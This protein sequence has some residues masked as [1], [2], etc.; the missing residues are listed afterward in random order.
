MDKE[1]VSVT[2]AESGDIIVNFKVGISLSVY[3][4]ALNSINEMLGPNAPVVISGSMG[5]KMSLPPESPVK[6]VRKSSKN[7]SNKSGKS[8]SSRGKN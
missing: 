5:I 2:L 7:S 1:L 3:T 8:K 4:A 6:R